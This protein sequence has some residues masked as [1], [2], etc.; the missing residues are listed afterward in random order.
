[1]RA[2]D[3]MVELA[4]VDEQRLA[5]PIAEALARLVARHRAVRQHEAG[6]A[7]RREVMNDVLHPEVRSCVKL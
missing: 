3:Q 1:M 7:V 5:A 4:R 2:I 6:D